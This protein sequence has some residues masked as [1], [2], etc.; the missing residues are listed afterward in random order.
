[1]RLLDIRKRPRF[2]VAVAMH[3]HVGFKRL[4]LGKSTI[5]DF[6]QFGPCILAI[7]LRPAPDTLGICHQRG[8]YRVLPI[9]VHLLA[10]VV[11][12]PVT[13]DAAQG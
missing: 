10:H 12:G 3:Q 7:V 11:V 13:Q 6:R 9:D 4:V 5:F 2:E 8:H 1:M